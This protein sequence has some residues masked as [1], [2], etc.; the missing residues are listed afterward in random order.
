M[1]IS[2]RPTEDAAL[3]GDLYYAFLERVRENS[4][5]P[6]TGRLVLAGSPEI[7]VKLAQSGF[8][9]L[10]PPGIWGATVEAFED[11]GLEI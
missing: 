2:A 6:H 11:A 1:S 3:T 5:K 9:P 7:A 10:V 8:V 4:G